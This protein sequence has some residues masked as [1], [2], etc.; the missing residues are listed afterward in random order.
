MRVR[1]RVCMCVRVRARAHLRALDAKSDILCDDALQEVLGTEVK[2]VRAR[3]KDVHF[4]G[5]LRARACVCVSV[6]AHVCVAATFS[7][8]S[9]AKPTWIVA[10]GTGAGGGASLGS[11]CTRTQPF[12][13]TRAPHTRALHLRRGLLDRGGRAGE[14]ARVHVRGLCLGAVEAEV[15]AGRDLRADHEVRERRVPARLSV[16]RERARSRVCVHMGEHIYEC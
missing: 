16:A 2:R 10:S 14:D 6:R 11:G 5:N 7:P 3:R 4:G 13:H 15:G 1:V 9:C 8:E 12:A